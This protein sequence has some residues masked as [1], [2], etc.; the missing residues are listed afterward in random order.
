MVM[1]A[2]G[3]KVQ[4]KLLSPEY[5]RSTR[6]LELCPPSSFTAPDCSL[7]QVSKQTQ[8]LGYPGSTKNDDGLRSLANGS[9]TVDTHI[10]TVEENDNAI[11]MVMASTK[12]VLPEAVNK[13]NT[14]STSSGLNS[15]ADGSTLISTSM[16]TTGQA[17]SRK[18]ELLTEKGQERKPTKRT[19]HLVDPVPMSLS[20][21]NQFMKAAGLC[22][23]ATSKRK[24][25]YTD[26]PGE[27]QLHR[28]L[29]ARYEAKWH[30]NIKSMD[31]VQATAAPQREA[32]SQ[33]TRERQ[34]D[35][36]K[37]GVPGTIITQHKPC[38]GS[39][40]T[41]SRGEALSR[42]EAAGSTRERRE[43]KDYV[44]HFVEQSSSLQFPLVSIS[45]TSAQP[46]SSKNV[47]SQME[48]DGC[49]SDIAL[50]ELL[51][52]EEYSGGVAGGGR[53]VGQRD[54]DFEIARNM[55]QEYDEEMA[56]VLHASE[57]QPVNNYKQGKQF[58][59]IDV[60]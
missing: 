30:S 12:T 52:C 37:E 7:Q 43:Q 48:P 9:S 28:A 29:A 47:C 23:M 19:S 40:E 32:S 49:D 35:T 55:Q 3:T 34:I 31:Y 24:W 44:K 42:G 13:P 18:K 33:S 50:A 38:G 20:N 60:P 6:T 5:F 8:Q 11:S 51:Q 14:L 22:A 45:T 1:E 27:V 4:S 53:C 16:T 17:Q 25:E 26:D 39:G 10:N 2:D 54:S 56:Q 21:D 57:Q 59:Y 46:S 36:L 41:I 15:D 58:V